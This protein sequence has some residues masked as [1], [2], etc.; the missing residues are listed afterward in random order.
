ME[1]QMKKYP[2]IKIVG[3]IDGM[4]TDTIVKSQM[5]QYLS[6]HLAA[7]NGVFVQSP[8]EVG[9]LEALQASGRPI[10]PITLAGE[11]GTACYWSTHPNWATGVAYVWPPVAEIGV[12]FDVL[13]RTLQGQ[14]PINQSIVWTPV[15]G[16][17]AQIKT[18]LPA[19]CST[20]STDW[21]GPSPSQ[22]VPDSKLNGFFKHGKPLL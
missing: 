11:V 4:W 22:Y 17:L 21:I 16:T 9:A 12:S 18:Q 19:S 13:M 20:S 15:S 10:V 2:N 8:G 1:I 3:K 14:D 5:L 7:I 6:T